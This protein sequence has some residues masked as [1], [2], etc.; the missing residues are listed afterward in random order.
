MQVMRVGRAN[1]PGATADLTARWTGFLAP[2]L[3]GRYRLVFVASGPVVVRID[4]KLVIL[5]LP[6]RDVAIALSDKPIAIGVEF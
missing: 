2:Q 5:N 6:R 3:A 4:E 1:R